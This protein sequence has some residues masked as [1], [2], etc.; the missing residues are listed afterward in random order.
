MSKYTTGELAKLCGVSVRTV[1][2]YDTRGILCP[3]ELS[4]GGRRLYSDADVSRMRIICFLRGI[5]L[6]INSIGQLLDESDPGSVISLL[7]EQQAQTLADEIAERQKQLETLSVLQQEIKRTPNFSVE[8]IHDIATLMENRKKLRNMR[9]LV[10]VVGILADIL[11]WDSLL[12]WIFLGWWQAFVVCM[13]IAIALCAW[14]VR[15]YF[16]RVE[17]ICPQCHTVFRPSL[18]ETF[19]AHH[20]PRTRKLHCPACGYH[21]FCVETL[22]AEV[23]E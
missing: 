8:S 13:V 17:Y 3:S 6:P 14:I 15:Y 19:W 11:E 20:T 4:E 18:K 2:Y 16:T 22:R 1:Q 5:G 9:I 7:L 10:T 12:L 21:G 23:A